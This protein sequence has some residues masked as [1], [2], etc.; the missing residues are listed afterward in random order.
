MALVS[1]LFSNLMH[2]KL[3]T[4]FQSLGFNDIESIP[5]SPKASVLT[6]SGGNRLDSVGLTLTSGATFTH[7]GTGGTSSSLT[8]GSSEYWVTAKLCKGVKDSQT[9]NFYILATTS[10]GR[11][12]AA[13][14][15]TSDCTTF[16]APTGWQIVGF[17]GQSGDEM[18]QLAFIYA[19]Q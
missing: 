10:T 6:F 19:P 3:N 16:S 18:D 2:L 12:L 15:S 1:L 13:G 8:L 9:R 5:S 14:T 7:G 4:D 11:T 17:L